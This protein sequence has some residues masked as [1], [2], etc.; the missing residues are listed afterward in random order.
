MATTAILPEIRKRIVY[1]RQTKDYDCY[2]SIDGDPE[3]Y[4]AQDREDCPGPS[5][6]SGR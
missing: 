5:G 6:E 1:N 4:I 2:I 3:R